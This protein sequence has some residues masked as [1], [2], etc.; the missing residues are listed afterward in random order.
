[1]QPKAVIIAGANGAGKTTF[2]GNMLP[3]DHPECLFLNADEIQHEAPEF[4]S[5]AAAGRELLQ[6]LSA[7]T[8]A[9][10]S[11]AVETTLSSRLYARKIPDWRAAGFS[12]WLYFLDV[13]TAD[14]AVAR[15]AMRVAAGGHDIPTADIVR[16]HARNRM[17]FP[18]YQQLS[19]AWYHFR[20]DEKGTQLVDFQEP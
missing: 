13:E 18:A 15:V 7:L 14:L 9:K 1:M 16:R 4:R 8:I 6:R 19:D 10:Q 5:P 17:L 2:A 11:F 12:V 20:V 3:Q